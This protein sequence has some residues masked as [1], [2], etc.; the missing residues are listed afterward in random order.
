MHF[1]AMLVLSLLSAAPAQAPPR[2]LACF[3]GLDRATDTTFASF[4]LNVL[5][6]LQAD[7][8]GVVAKQRS[9]GSGAW[10]LEAKFLEV[11]DE[12][13][14]NLEAHLLSPR[15]NSC[16]RTLLQ[17]TSYTSRRNAL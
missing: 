10:R 1:F 6:T 15:L 5:T 16:S 13:G 7:L 4:K 14:V 3:W 8:C 2:V 17:R 9:D 12:P 11:V